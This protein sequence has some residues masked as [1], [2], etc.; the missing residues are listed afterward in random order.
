MVQRELDDK[1]NKMSAAQ[2]EEKIKEDKPGRNDIPNVHNI[3]AYVRKHLKALRKE[4]ACSLIE[5]DK[6]STSAKPSNST[7]LLYSGGIRRG[8]GKDC[9]Y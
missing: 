7:A 2:M 5:N 3:W 4:T 6:S 1:S 8:F 9:W